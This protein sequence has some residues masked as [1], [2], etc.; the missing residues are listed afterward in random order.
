MGSSRLRTSVVTFGLMPCLFHVTGIIASAQFKQIGPAP[1]SP[2][3]ARR[4]FRTMLEKVDSSNIQQTVKALT[5]L[6][7]WYRDLLD[8]ELVAAWEREDRANLPDVI[9]PLADP[10]VAAEI[11]QFS[12][13]NQRQATFRPAYA[14]MLGHLMARYAESAK[15]F[16]DDLLSNAATDQPALNLS[17]PEAEAVC[18]ILL[19][20][21]DI[22]TWKTSALKILPRYRQ[23]AGRLLDQDLRADDLNKRYRALRWQADLAAVDS[24]F[25]ARR[26]AQTAVRGNPGNP[27]PATSGPTS[28]GAYRIGNGVTAPALLSRVEPEYSNVARKLRVMD[29]TVVLRLIV[30]PDGSARDIRVLRPMGYGL[31]EKAMEA[32]QKWRFK[33][34]FKDGNAVPVEAQI[35]TNFR[36]L[37][38]PGESNVWY[39]GP[40]AFRSE[41]GFTPPEVRD[42]TM[43]KPV[44]DS[45]DET[46]IFEFTVDTSGSV[47]NIHVISGST[48]AAEVL[49]RSLAAWKFEPAM[50]ENRPVEATGRIRFFKGQG[51]DTVTRPLSPPTQA[52]R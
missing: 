32:V 20:M 23:E 9:E 24:G 3:V 12:W 28:S 4:Q 42:G 34:G 5:D 1:I 22:Q 45:S 44:R 35:Q 19:D 43:P 52:I 13:H 39:S 2:V 8:E 26:R 18:R 36:I 25:D 51:D 41:A 46:A 16:L 21:P 11:V 47:M 15:P 6:T 17:Q 50:K 38:R 14:P 49:T 10:R 29:A 37:R 27:L 33:P 7:P 40:M 48:S 31:E 30:E